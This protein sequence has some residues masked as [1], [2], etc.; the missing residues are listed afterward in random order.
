MAA[1]A[2]NLEVST[3]S[4]SLDAWLSRLPGDACAAFVALR[5]QAQKL[6]S[7]PVAARERFVVL[8]RMRDH[9]L[10]LMPELR[11]R[12]LS[13]PVPLDGSERQ[14]WEVALGLWEAFY[15]AYALCSES[16][17]AP[18]HA[19]IV[20]QRALDCLGRAIREHAFAYHAVPSGLWKELNSCYRTVEGCALADIGVADVMGADASCKRSYLATVLHDAGNLYALTTPQMSALEQ[21]LPAWAALVD[22]VT[23]HP[24]DAARSPL[25]IDV[26]SDTGAQLARSLQPSETLHYLETGALAPRLREISA[27]VRS[28]TLPLELAA[29]RSLGRQATER[30]LTHLYIQ[31]CSAGQGRLD[32]RHASTRR[33]QIALNM[34]A[35]HFQISGR[36][37]RQPGLSYTREE[38]HD[39]ATFGHITERTEQRLLTSRSSALEPWEVV[40]QSASGLMS[41]MRKPDLESRIHHGQL[42]AMRT[43]SIEPPMLGVVQRLRIENGGQLGIGVRVI[44]GESRGAAVRVF[45]DATLKYERALIVEADKERDTPAFLVLPP[46]AYAL[47][48]TLELHTGRAEKIV[49]VSLLEQCEDHDRAT[50]RPA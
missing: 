9:A 35:I 11:S 37:F 48:S 41:M 1:T 45:G 3:D 4:S 2:A 17:A 49:L 39:L 32:E 36:A 28:G 14:A 33:A 12:Y 10:K 40:N 46:G 31:W 24:A 23:A 34:H 7:S 47:G 43:S 5:D 42:I 25:A 50:Y 20:W 19:A 15:F 29:T 16:G 21:L 38:E 13:K 22:L 8:E 26:A 18:E 44:R 30:L 6:A 27:A